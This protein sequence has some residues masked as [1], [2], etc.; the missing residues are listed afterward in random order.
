MPACPKSNDKPLDVQG[1]VSTNNCGSKNSDL[2][3]TWNRVCVCV[4]VCVC[5]HTC[6]YIFVCTCVAL[7]ISLCVCMCV[8]VHV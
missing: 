6:V 2:P 4:C 3:P 7:F 5:A 1:V 8:C